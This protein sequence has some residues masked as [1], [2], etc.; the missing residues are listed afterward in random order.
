MKKIKGYIFSRPFYDERVPQKIQN[1][2]IREFCKNKNYIYSLSAVEYRM[3][4]SSLILKD[5][6]NTLKNYDGIVAYSVFQLPSNMQLRKEIVENIIKNQKFL[7]F[8]IEDILV[9]KKNDYFELEKFWKIKLTLNK[10][11]KYGTI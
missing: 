1:L 5:L 3:N 9:K 11:Y 10:C 2:V 8:A 7:A 6:V 4:N